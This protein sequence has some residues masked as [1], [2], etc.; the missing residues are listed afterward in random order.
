MQLLSDAVR[1][2]FSKFPLRSQE[3][4]SDPLVVAKFFDP[5]GRFTFYATE[6]EEE[7]PDFTMFGFVVSPLDPDFDELGYMSLMEMQSVKNKFGLGIERDVNY[8]T[9]VKTLSTVRERRRSQQRQ[10]A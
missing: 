10:F 2:Q 7:G 4:V 8:P 5:C 9:C 3:K 1:K 6:G